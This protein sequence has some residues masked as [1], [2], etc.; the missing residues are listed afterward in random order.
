MRVFVAVAEEESFAR[1]A[2]RLRLSAPAVTRAI[3]ALEER[4]GVRLL[5]RTTRV[6]RVTEAGARF[7]T[8]AARVLADVDEAERGAAG[9]QHG[10]RGALTV[11]APSLFGRIHAAPVLL[12]FLE[13]HPEVTGRGVFVDRVVDLVEEGID[14]AIRIARLGDSALAA[15]RVGAVRRVVCASPAYLKKSAKLATP[16]DLAKHDAIAFA[17]AAEQADWTFGAGASQVTARPRTRLVVNSSDVAIDAALAGAGVIRALSYQVASQVRD[18]ALVIVLAKFEP[19][20]VPVHVVHAEGRRATTRV[21]AFVDFA[22][23][24][25]RAALAPASP[26]GP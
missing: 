7:V 18:G 6:V 24:R 1:A 20:E 9:V 25:L 17:A 26:S 12:E 10:L 22:V 15:V 4:I 21:R 3:A 2:R 13:R 8:D 5:H 11:T 19:P 23:P 16:R 14:V